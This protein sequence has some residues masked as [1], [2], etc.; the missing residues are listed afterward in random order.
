MEH[1]KRAFALGVW[2]SPRKAPVLFTK[3]CLS[4]ADDT[5]KF[6]NLKSWGRGIREQEEKQVSFADYQEEHHVFLGL[7]CLSLPL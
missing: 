5:G 4:T 1:R 2:V 7:S 6:S 3:Q